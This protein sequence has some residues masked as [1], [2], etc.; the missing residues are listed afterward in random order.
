MGFSRSQHLVQFLMLLAVYS[1]AVSHPIL[2]LVSQDLTFFLYHGADGQLI[3]W[4]WMLI[5]LGVPLLIY[6]LLRL[7]SLIRPKTF[8]M[9]LRLVCS[10]FATLF[11][12]ILVNSTGVEIN[13]FVAVLVAI[14]SGSGF[15]HFFRYKAFQN[16][17]AILHC[18]VAIS[19]IQ[20]FFFSDVSHVYKKGLPPSVAR[21]EIRANI[22]TFLIVLD[23]LSVSSILDSQ[24]RGY[25]INGKLFPGL[26][27]LSMN[28][29]W[30][31]NASTVS[32]ATAESIP[33]IVTGKYPVSGKPPY[34]SAY[35]DNIIGLFS[36]TLDS[37]VVESSTRFDESV[38]VPIKHG[39]TEGLFSDSVVLYA[40]LTYPHEWRDNLPSVRQ[41]KGDFLGNQKP[42]LKNSKSSQSTRSNV[43][44][45]RGFI[46][47]ISKTDLPKFHFLHLIFPHVPW[48]TLPSTKQ[49]SPGRDLPG[50]NRETETWLD[51]EYFV[52]HNYQRHLLQSAAADKLI[53]EFLTRLKDLAM[54]EK[55]LIIV[56]ADHGVSFHPNSH[57]RSAEL[58]NNP[59][60]I[61]SVP[62]FIKFPMQGEARVSDRN[63]ET[64]DIVP[65]LADVLGLD[66]PWTT[67]GT[68][69]LDNQIPER[70][71]KRVLSWDWTPSGNQPNRP[72]DSWSDYAKDQTENIHLGVDYK[73][74]YFVDRDP[75][76]AFDYEWTLSTRNSARGLVNAGEVELRGQID[77]NPDSISNARNYPGQYAISRLAGVVTGVSKESA[78]VVEIKSGNLHLAPVVDGK[79]SLMIDEHTYEEF[80]NGVTIWVMEPRERM[81]KPHVVW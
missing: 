33:A 35:P 38:A 79:F 69:L 21:T 15:F 13:P 24:E 34:K 10:M 5:A 53:S 29:Y 72:K 57:R 47:G 8:E 31:R 66:L 54:F 52:L 81:L 67:D 43:D 14:L 37:F 73:F 48:N 4:Y 22:P 78:I 58:V 11:F 71:S 7:I 70:P 1:F 60:D 26:H 28:A 2:Q 19:A 3:L 32:V 56:T 39:I 18:F 30:Y 20:F 63:V 74:R 46:D 77:L 61:I 59:S 80:L 36:R 16:Y 64:V 76:F 50:L 75:W 9:S 17:L 65:T 41:E 51:N 55:S 49:Y 68:S 44:L 45:F 40:H 23:E 42:R 27:E 6:A 25:G 62:L 12:L